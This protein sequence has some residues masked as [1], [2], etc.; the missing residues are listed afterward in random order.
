MQLMVSMVDDRAQ[1]NP[2]RSG[3]AP[4]RIGLRRPVHVALRGGVAV[5]VVLG[6]LVVG[7]D[8]LFG[9][10]IP[11]EKARSFQRTRHPRQ[12]RKTIGR[13]GNRRHA[14]QQSKSAC[15]LVT[16]ASQV[17]FRHT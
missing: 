15:A 11:P 5:E 8:H 12:A 9:R 14:V 4:K 17:R 6:T 2:V 7:D 10:S 3:V 16:G 1:T 13:H